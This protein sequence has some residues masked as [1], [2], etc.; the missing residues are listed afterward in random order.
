[1]AS[2]ACLSECS[3]LVSENSIASGGIRVHV[4][5]RNA[6]RKQCE[7]EEAEPFGKTHFLSLTQVQSVQWKIGSI[8]A[9]A[10]CPGNGL[11]R[12]PLLCVEGVGP[13]PSFTI[14]LRQRGNA[15]EMKLCR[16][17]QMSM[18]PHFLYCYLVGSLDFN[19]LDTP[20]IS[21]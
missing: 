7:A 15:S 1:M 17:A 2:G 8:G 13:L 10:I 21:F 20:H 12:V 6:V 19:L 5:C 9:K 16:I 18:S 14:R 3:W 4:R 11:I